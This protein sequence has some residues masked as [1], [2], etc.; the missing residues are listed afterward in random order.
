[1]Q[2]SSRDLAPYLEILFALYT[3]WSLHVV[4][5]RRWDMQRQEYP[6]Y[7]AIALCVA[8]LDACVDVAQALCCA[9]WCA[10]RQ[11]PAQA[12][13]LLL[14]RARPDVRDCC[15]EWGSGN[16]SDGP[17]NIIRCANPQAVT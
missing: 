8:L 11:D 13:I 9:G 4:A 12:C 7:G 1:M 3:S 10:R 16:L 6:W 2:Q 17:Y 14:V 5:L 15:R